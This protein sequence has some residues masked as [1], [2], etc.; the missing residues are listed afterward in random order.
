MFA[1]EP[2]SNPPLSPGEHLRMLIELMKPAGP[3]MARRWLA[4]LLCVPESER[5]ALLAE[6]E[7]RAAALASRA[8]SPGPVEVTLHHPPVQHDGYIEQ[9]STTYARNAPTAAKPERHCRTGD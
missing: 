3:D 4:C 9:V 6:M 8:P 7:A 5:P 2:E 1:F